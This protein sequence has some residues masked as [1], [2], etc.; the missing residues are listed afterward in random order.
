MNELLQT[1]NGQMLLHEGFDPNNP[2][3]YNRDWFGWANGLFCLWVHKDWL[4]HNDGQ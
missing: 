3:L 4:P 2:S 1:D